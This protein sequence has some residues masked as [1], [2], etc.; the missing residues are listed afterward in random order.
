MAK[1][2]IS[3]AVHFHDGMLR[4]IAGIVCESLVKKTE[5]GRR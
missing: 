4:Q 3:G 2:Q 5:D 1:L